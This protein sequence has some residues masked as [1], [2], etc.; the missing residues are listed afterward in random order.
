MT[1]QV[2]KEEFWN[3]RW[4]LMPEEDLRKFQLE[5]IQAQLE[6]VYHNS[7]FYR[8]LYDRHKVKP[9]DIKTL[10]DFAEKVPIFRKDELREYYADTGDPLAGLLCV[11]KEQLVAYWSSSG[12][13]GMPTFGAYTRS[14]LDVATEYVCRC[15][16]DAGYRA[17][18]K[19]MLLNIN[20][21]WLMPILW[22]AVRRLGL[23]PI[24]VDFPHPLFSERWGR[25]IMMYKP[26]V[27][28]GITTEMARI[29]IPQAL[30]KL[31]EDPAKV[32]SKVKILSTMGEALTPVARQRLTELWG[33]VA[34]RDFVGT[35][36]SSA[37]FIEG[38]CDHKEGGHIYTD[39]TYVEAVDP[40]TGEPLPKGELGE[41]V[42]TNLQYTALPFIRF[43]LEDLIR[44]GT[45]PC[46]R[47]ITHPYGRVYG[48]A[49]WRIKISGKTIIPW[50]IEIILQKHRETEKAMFALIKYAKEMDT[51]KI[52]AAYDSQ[53]TADEK[54]LK[55]QLEKEIKEELG[56]STQI[57]WVAEESLP[58][59]VPHK[60]I[61]FIDETK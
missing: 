13:T 5:R 19:A 37:T 39:I 40:D 56:V 50:D 60:I 51:L 8:R 22:G 24:V 14:D 44:L 53:L 42:T 34:I 25:I 36:E 29:F 46:H 27:I 9:G 41:M 20:W 61:K 52:R 49:G 10:E 57:E 1:S 3:P 54:A 55:T 48:R 26:E 18:Q 4:Q 31:G 59:P 43:G 16:W 32:L 17:G 2:K 21:H 7:P 33:G 15:F 23:S 28:P 58:R 6:Y 12:T 45:E 30:E 47:G 11:P 35:G 38:A